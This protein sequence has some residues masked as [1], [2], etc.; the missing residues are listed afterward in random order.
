VE[1]TERAQ[2][3]KT[4]AETPTR[5]KA[6]LKGV[7]KKLGAARPAPG[8]WSILEIVCHM[9]D[10]EAE[11]Y[12]ARYRRILAED[13]PSLPDIDGDAIAIERD[14]RSQSLAAALR[15][16]SKLRKESLKLLKKVKGGQ[17][18]RIGTHQ[19]AGRFS[20][21]D[22]LRRQAVGNDQAHLGQIEA[23]LR[24]FALLIRLAAGP[25]A[26]AEA[27]KGLDGAE[28]KRRPADGKWS[29]VE[30]ACHMRDLELVFAERFTKMAFSERPTFWMLDNDRAAAEKK[31]SEADLGAAAKSFKELRQETLTLLKAL[32]A[33][34]WRRTGLHPK[35]GELSVEQLAEHLGNHDDKH[36]GQIRELRS[37]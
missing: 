4:L 33:A 24:R 18:E 19:T 13:N 3:L 16:W 26:L 30:N 8:K 20:V 37:S 36:I 11:A 27:V 6:A 23:A 7:S 28:A 15:A 17:W 22:F 14:Y 5:L 21:A 29:I 35:R 9:R 10:M 31:Y 2:H 1:E 34:T 12:L 25:G 32:P